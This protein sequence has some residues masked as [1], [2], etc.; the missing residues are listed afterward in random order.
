MRTACIQMCSNDAVEAN[1]EV[2]A[3][4]LE[5]AAGQGVQLA[6]LPENFALMGAD[7]QGRRQLAEELYHTMVLPFLAAQARRHAMFIV[8]G[9]VLMAGSEGRLRNACP[10]FGPDGECLACYDK[11]HLF[12]VDLPGERHRE[13]DTV[14]AGARPVQV[15]LAGWRLGLSICYDLRFPELYRHYARAGCQ[16]LTVPAAFTVPTGQAH[17]EILLRARAIENQA[18]VLAAAQG[19]CHPDGRRTWGHSMIIDPWGDILASTGGNEVAEEAVLVVADLD[20]ERL[21]LIRRQLPAL[22]HRRLD[23]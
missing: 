20:R 4:L 8:G 2:A 3:R 5:K 17:W 13:S 23:A 1:L 12:D 7:A 22:E 11:L 14:V 19:G 9:S 6:V 21:T 18:Y 10:V 15:D 16:V